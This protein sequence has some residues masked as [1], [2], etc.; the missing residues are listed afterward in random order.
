MNHSI[1]ELKKIVDG[2][3]EWWQGEMF[4]WTNRHQKGEWD[5]GKKYDVEQMALAK[6]EMDTAIKRVEFYQ[7]ISEVL[8]GST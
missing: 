7:D 1:S 5:N 2:K 8:N 6:K 4:I 3:I